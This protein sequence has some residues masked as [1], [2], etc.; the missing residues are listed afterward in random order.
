MGHV[1]QRF[2]SRA[3]ALCY[4]AP[5]TVSPLVCPRVFRFGIRAE[6]VRWYLK[7]FTHVCVAWGYDVAPYIQFAFPLCA[8][9][10]CCREDGILG[11]SRL[12][13]CSHERIFD[14]LLIADLGC[15][16]LVKVFIAFQVLS[17]H[18]VNV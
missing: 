9:Y 6:H 16:L 1:Q 18:K 8:Q 5:P 11:Y 17:V 3:R 7:P 2:S 10:G 4:C 14:Q 13:I 15:A 12:F